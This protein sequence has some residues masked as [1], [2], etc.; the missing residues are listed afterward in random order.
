MAFKLEIVVGGMCM[1]VQR[2]NGQKRGLYI[3]M[4]VTQDHVAVLHYRTPG[5]DPVSRPLNGKIVDGRGIGPDGTAKPFDP[6]IAPISTFAGNRPVKEKCLLGGNSTL[7]P[8][9]TA[10]VDLPLGGTVT[11]WGHTAFV[12]VVSGGTTRQYDLTGFVAITYTVD[13]EFLELADVELRPNPGSNLKIGILNI[14]T[15]EI[16]TIPKVLARHPQPLD[17]IQHPG[18]NKPVEHFHGYYPLID[19]CPNTPHGPPCGPIPA[20]RGRSAL[21]EHDPDQ[22]LIYV[23]P[24]K[25]IITAARAPA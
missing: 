5:G 2:A 4:P 22:A 9:L 13:E 3:L 18:P 21:P 12:T 11:P 6:A 14:P 24:Y 23:N 17:P 25:C 7:L 20:S 16:D 15:G 19:G 10:R 8:L 1:L